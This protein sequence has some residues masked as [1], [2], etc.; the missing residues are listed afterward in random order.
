[1][2]DPAETSSDRVMVA[3]ALAAGLSMVP[4]LFAAV[5][6]VRPTCSGPV[7]DWHPVGEKCSP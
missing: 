6:V 3:T 5:E 4:L 7:C 1:M 2:K